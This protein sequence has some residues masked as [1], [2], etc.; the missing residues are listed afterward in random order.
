VASGPPRSTC[1][2][3]A[4]ALVD[5]AQWARS[6]DAARTIIAACFQQRLVG[7]AE[8]TEVLDRTP[9]LRRHALIAATVADAVG[10][11]HSLGELAFLELC[12]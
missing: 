6:D 1:T 12:R 4:R 3:P 11:A 7:L 8:V 10:G 2:S 5:A 9:N